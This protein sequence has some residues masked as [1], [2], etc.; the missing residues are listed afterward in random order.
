MNRNLVGSIAAAVIIAGGF[1]LY[2]KSQSEAPQSDKG[3][4][5]VNP[6]GGDENSLIGGK[7][8]AEPPSKLTSDEKKKY[9][10]KLFA[11]GYTED[12]NEPYHFVKKT[13]KPDG[14]I[15][16]HVMPKDPGDN[17]YFEPQERDQK[18]AEETLERKQE[19]NPAEEIVSLKRLND[20]D[21]N[22]MMMLGKFRDEANDLEIRFAP[23]SDLENNPLEKDMT[24]LVSPKLKLNFKKTLN[25]E[26]KSDDTGYALLKLNDETFARVAWSADSEGR[27]LH[28]HIL[29]KKNGSFQMTKSFVAKE[30][31]NPLKYCQ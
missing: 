5:V 3:E 8:T 11:Q 23:V 15:V 28:G 26:V 20:N 4:T 22:T 21:Q 13:K 25:G 30:F 6:G 17:V 7:P 12:P 9:Q 29:V 2:K 24:C 18:I 1:F 16:T 31:H 14:K 19:L 10:D 27:K